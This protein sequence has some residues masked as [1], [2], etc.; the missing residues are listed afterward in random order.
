MLEHATG[1]S[2]NFGLNVLISSSHHLSHP[3][4]EY[5]SSNLSCTFAYLVIQFDSMILNSVDDN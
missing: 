5:I 3:G 4:R 1:Y 2:P